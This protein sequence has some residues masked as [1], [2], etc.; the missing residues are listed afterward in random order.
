L[1]LETRE[2]GRVQQ[3]IG[4]KPF[5]A[6]F[7]EHGATRLG[8]KRRQASRDREYIR[9]VFAVSREIRQNLELR[10]KKETSNPSEFLPQLT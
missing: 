10:G 5:Q 9:A 8:R 2:T 3:A 4:T 7:R 6:L 1:E